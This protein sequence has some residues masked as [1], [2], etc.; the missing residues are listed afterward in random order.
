MPNIVIVDDEAIFRRGLR[1]MIASLD[2]EWNVVGDA[3]DG[4][5]ALDL[6]QERRPDVMLTDIR[7]PRMD[8]L[9]LQKIARERFPELVS[10][11]V[12]GYED[13]AYVKQSMQHGAKDYLMKPIERE[14][15]AKLLQRLK[16]EVRERAERR[17]AA[18][19]PREDHRRTREQLGEHLAAVLLRGT[20]AEE[21]VRR[22]ETIGIR[23]DKP[24]FMCMTV[25]LDKRSVGP[26]R[27]RQQDP[28]LFQLYIQQFVQEIVD[29]RT[30]GFCFVLNDSEVVA[31]LNSDGGEDAMRKHLEMAESIR[32]QIKSLSNLTVTIG[33]GRLAPGAASLAKSY[34]EAEIALLHR[35]IVGGDKVLAYERTMEA[36]MPAAAEPREWSWEAL[37]RAIAGGRADEA[38]ARAKEAAAE[39]CRMAATPQ[40]VH[41]HICKLV[42]RYYELS[43]EWGVAKAWLGEKD[44]RELLFDVCS[45]SA[46]DELTELCGSLF[47]RL[48]ACVAASGADRPTDPIAKAIRYMETNYEKPITL[49]R[50]AEMLFLNP[51]YFS[52]LFK[53]RTG[54]TFVERLT[55]IRVE[56]AKRRLAATNELV[57]EVA[58]RT[59]FRNVRHF[60]RVFKTET[61]VSPTEYRERA[62]AED[63]GR[64]RNG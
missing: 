15:L 45:I 29:R 42:I 60:N 47:G 16:A 19:E 33:L 31:L 23:F 18:A 61:G 63:A 9:Q 40:T 52:A 59:G 13:F 62:R 39:L 24:C 55:S 46:S 28:S 5:E 57:T 7:M 64:S 1:S 50:M 26:D 14:E 44:V 49:G 58:E 12:S 48:A 4:Y 32:L 10:A 30:K 17:G 36:G 6:L 38:D 8:G 27:Y 51:A 54:A 53:Q 35:L 3:R 43:S 22:L 11:V 56:A 34:R 21:D 25:K 20:V 2:P 37:E 41:R